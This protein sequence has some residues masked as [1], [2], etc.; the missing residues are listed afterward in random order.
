MTAALA[1]AVFAVFKRYIVPRTASILNHVTDHANVSDERSEPLKD[2]SEIEIDEEIQEQLD[3]AEEDKEITEHKDTVSVDLI[4][5]AGQSN[6]A[7]WGGD[8]SKAPKLTEGAGAEFRAVS[9]PTKLYT[10]T[11]PFGF[12]ENTE[13][14]NDMFMKRGSLVTAFVNAYYKETGV[15]VVAVSASKGGTPSTYWA[16]DVVG[17]DVVTRY[18]N[19]KTWLVE[20]GYTIRN[21]FVVFLQGE[22]DVIENVSDSQYLADINTF[23]SKLFYKGIDKFMMIRV[24]RTI[25]DASIYDRISKLQTELCRTDPRFVLVSVLLSKL[26]ESYMVDEYH[27]DQDALNLLGEDAGVNAAYFA[28]TRHDPEFIDPLT[29][30]MYEPIY[31]E[32]Q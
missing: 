21:Q 29:G 32:G 27:Y 5:F 7:G 24:G 23:S 11:E 12:Y 19:A 28:K 1:A 30:E 15:P 4:V 10:I 3:K 20:N 25:S 14:M 8:A 9:D 17:D 2:A 26:D 22:N 6:M 18:M 13:T 16:T 31:Y